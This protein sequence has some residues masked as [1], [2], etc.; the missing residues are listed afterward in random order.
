MIYIYLLL[1]LFGAANTT[2]KEWEKST[3]NYTPI[4]YTMLYKIV[5][6]LGFIVAIIALI[7]ACTQEWWYPIGMII[8]SITINRI[9]LP[10]FNSLGMRHMI[11]LLS[12]VAIPVL[13]IILLCSIS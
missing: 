7:V 9:M 12:L 11:N 6:I 1:T 5:G 3:Y 8:A 4:F 10:I 13:A 2:T